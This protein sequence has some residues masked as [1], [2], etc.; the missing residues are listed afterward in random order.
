MDQPQHTGTLA[1]ALTNATKLLGVRPALAEEQAGEI[2][3]VVPGEPRALLLLGRAR[4]AQ[5]NDAGARQVLEPLVRKHPD[6][7]D[8]HYALG[9]ILSARGEDAAADRAYARALKASTRNPKLVEAAAALCEN[10]LAVAERLLRDYLKSH[11]TDI[12]AIRMLAETGARLGA[13]QDAETLLRRAIELSPGFTAARHNL[14]MVLHR[15]QKSFDAIAEIDVLLAGDKRN[16]GYRALRAAA[17]VRIGEFEQAITAYESLLK[18]CPALAKGWMSYG[19]TLKTVG[20]QGDSVAAYRKSLGLEPS[21]GE[22]WWSLANLKTFRFT[23]DDTA[24]MRKQVARRDIEDEDRFHLHFAL[25]KA[26]EDEG[27]Y[28]DSFAQYRLANA[29]RRKSVKYEPEALSDHLRRTRA[30]FTPAFFASRH[31]VGS[32]ARDP[33]FVVS[34]PRAGS[35]LIEQILSSHSQVEGTMELSDIASLARGLDGHTLHRAQSRYPELLADIEPARFREIGDDYLARTRVHRK[36]GR[37]FFVDKM[38]NNFLHVGF[39]HLILPN[40]RIID[41]RRHPMACCLSNFKQHFARGQTFSYDLADL[42]RYWRD[43]A[44]LMAHFDAVLPG[45]VHRV[46]Y[47]DMVAEP[48]REIR[49]LLDHCGLPFEE[50]C[51]RFYETERAVRTASSE[52]VRQPIFTDGVE[53]WHRFEPWLGELRDALGPAVDAYPGVAEF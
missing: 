16:P 20:R 24:T 22:T 44:S 53:Q 45:R 9:E 38:P 15:Q 17:L 27:L 37:P 11:P 33:I 13:Y 36:L 8:A 46:F 14:A 51:L 42:G 18:D 2:L 7:A 43:Y 25:G 10:R 35:T 19:H 40:A 48:E 31:G 29:L 47:E 12:A 32:P 3:K 6:L 5:G 4:W 39:I 23:A 1:T 34:M 26:L 21:L 50:Q 49:R 52:Q 28:E 30:V 41:A